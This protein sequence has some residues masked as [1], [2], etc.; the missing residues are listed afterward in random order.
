LA[1]LRLT[2]FTKVSKNNTILWKNPTPSF[3]RYCRPIQSM[4]NKD[5]VETTKNEVQKVKK[6]IAELIPLN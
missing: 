6:E 4:Y 1:T 5:T 2:G 3:T